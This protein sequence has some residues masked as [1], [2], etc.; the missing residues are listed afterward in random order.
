[1]KKH[2][3]QHK[4]MNGRDYRVI[5]TLAQNNMRT[6]ETAYAMGL[7]RNSVMYRIGKIKKMTGLDPT[8]FY[9][10]IELVKMAKE[11]GYE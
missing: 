9:D 10:L 8:V 7:H 2:V 3:I 11:A 6:T 5:L 1:M 4:P